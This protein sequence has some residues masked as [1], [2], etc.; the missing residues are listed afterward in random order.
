MEVRGVSNQ[1]FVIDICGAIFLHTAQA[2]CYAT[3]APSICH[4][5]P[6]EILMWTLPVHVGRE[7]KLPIALSCTAIGGYSCT[8]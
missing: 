5:E 7:Q 3:M 2:A 4:T 1:L 6:K 8:T